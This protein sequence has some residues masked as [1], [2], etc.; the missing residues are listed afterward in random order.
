[1]QTVFVVGITHNTHI[2]NSAIDLKFG[3]SEVNSI[4]FTEGYPKTSLK[5][6]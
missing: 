3:P 1:M 2:N 6:G 5:K 4:K